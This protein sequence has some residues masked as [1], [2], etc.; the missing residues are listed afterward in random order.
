MALGSAL[1]LMGSFFVALQPAAASQIAPCSFAAGAGTSVSP[2]LVGSPE[3]LVMVQNCHGSGNDLFFQQTADV[4]LGSISNWTPIGNHTTAFNDNYDGGLYLIK[5]LTIDA[6]TTASSEF[7]LFGL[8][9]SGTDVYPE[10]RRIILSG[11]SL[12]V[13]VADPTHQVFVGALAGNLINDQ[14]SSLTTFSASGSVLVTGE[15]AAGSAT[16]GLIG[17]SAGAAAIP[18]GLRFDGTVSSSAEITGGLVGHLIYGGSRTANID[19]SSVVGS[20]SGAKY[21]GGFLGSF[22]NPTEKEFTV[23]NSYLSA[24][25]SSSASYSNRLIGNASGKLPKVGGSGIRVA[26]D[27][28]GG[29][30]DQT[31]IEGQVS[32]V[33]TSL[34]DSYWPNAITDGYTIDPNTTRFIFCDEVNRG[35]PVSMSFF[36]RQFSY[37][38]NPGSQ[39]NGT[40][41]CQMTFED[42]SVL[43]FPSDRAKVAVKLT[44][45][46]GYPAVEKSVVSIQ[47]DPSGLFRVSS[48][49]NN[50]ISLTVSA[51]LPAGSYPVSIKLD[52]PDVHLYT[53]RTIS[54]NVISCNYEGSGTTADPYVVDSANLLAQVANCSSDPSTEFKLTQDL[55]LSG[56]S[57]NPIGTNE[58]PFTGI[59]DGSGHTISGISVTGDLGDQFGRSS[60]DGA[61]L[62]GN[63]SEAEIKNLLASGNIIL[64]GEQASSIGGVVGNLNQSDVSNLSFTGEISAPS[65][66][67]LGGIVGESSNSTISNSAI[68]KLTMEGDD[69]LGGIVGFSENS[70]IISNSTISNLTME[71]DDDLGGIVGDSSDSTISN[72]AISNLTIKGK[73]DNLGG[74]VG[75][76]SD[77]TISNSAISKLTMEGDDNLGGIVGKSS[78]SKIT[79]SVVSNLNMSATGGSASKHGGLIGQMTGNS[80]LTKASVSGSITSEAQVGGA[81]GMLVSGEINFV[82]VKVNLNLVGDDINEIGGFVGNQAGGKISNSYAIGTISD[83]E[84]SQYSSPMSIGSFVGTLNSDSGSIIVNSYAAVEVLLDSP[85]THVKDA[86]F[87]GA[88][89]ANFDIIKSYLLG[90]DTTR[91]CTSPTLNCYDVT[92]TGAVA[93]KNIQTFETAGW[94]I[95][96]GW[97]AFSLT[98]DVP[99]PVNESI[100]GICASVNEGLPFLMHEAS[101][102]PCNTS[103]STPAA[104]SPAASPPAASPPAPYSGPIIMSVSSTQLSNPAGKSLTISGQR[105]SGTSSLTVDGKA[106]TIISKSDNVIEVTL[107]ELSIGSKNIILVSSSGVVTHQNSFEVV[108]EQA[109]GEQ[110]KVNVGSFNGKLVVYALGLDQARI[111]WKVGGIWGQ[112][113]ADGNTLNRFDRLTPRKGVTVKV[114]IFVDGVKRMTKSVLTR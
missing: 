46:T 12:R 44:P 50:E 13:A 103:A 39:F 100:W 101:A 92:A 19:I 40:G 43:F 36:S 2:Y 71:G 48:V 91:T 24:S 98:S 60:S 77:S 88:F 67:N 111:T 25:V 37:D 27:V 107:P 29:V 11:V 99:T 45:G 57:W 68:S 94:E 78:N 80:S 86:P 65:L 89:V 53:G 34:L 112:D 106:L 113:L 73:D 69:N 38:E 85:A 97:A 31:G 10:I 14:F 79:D 62:F 42:Q 5:N 90:V 30:V 104:S 4:D 17:K 52:R 59:F 76:S 6:R 35:L 22:D 58:K 83:A 72:S 15:A 64:E 114:D 84:G 7:G 51:T 55:D 87:A 1:A 93:M 26:I 74:I 56:R 9:D 70:T 105:L 23:R 81:V 16:G 33:S 63:V 18:T 66:D 108:L 8:A 49:V 95:Q 102:D 21:V 20:V 47:S 54:L 110:G 96:P 82:S 109:L 61:G 28:L 3:D 41:P 32:Q 75:N